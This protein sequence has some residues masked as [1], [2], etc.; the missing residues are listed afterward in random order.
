MFSA[1]RQLAK[2]LN[3]LFDQQP[4]D[5]FDSNSTVEK[6]LLPKDTL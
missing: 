2:E 1:G 4:K 5:A 6:N 3:V